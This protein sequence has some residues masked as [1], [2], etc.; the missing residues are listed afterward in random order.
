MIPRTNP[1]GRHPVLCFRAPAPVPY[2]AGAQPRRVGLPLCL[3]RPS[4]RAGPRPPCLRRPHSQDAT[5]SVIASPVCQHRPLPPTLHLPC[6]L[7][8]ALPV[9]ADAPPT[10]PPSPRHSYTVPPCCHVSYP[11]RHGA[12]LACGAQSP[13]KPRPSVLTAVVLA[14][15]FV[16]ACWMEPRGEEGEGRGRG[17]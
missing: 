14:H 16:N 2:S 7:F 5:P 1:C 4:M 17:G 8:C 6:F 12:C 13:C 3:G 15:P 10:P 9:G 11:S